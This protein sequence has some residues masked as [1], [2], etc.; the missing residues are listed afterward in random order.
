[1]PFM[2][3]G[4]VWLDGGKRQFTHDRRGR[5]ISESCDGRDRTFVY[6]SLDQLVEVRHPDGTNVRYEYDALRRR[7]A[8]EIGGKR[9]VFGW[10]GNR[11][12]WEVAADGTRR[13]YFY[14]KPEDYTPVM[15]CDV[16]VDGG[17]IKTYFIHHDHARRPILVTD[18][19]GDVVWSAE[20]AAYGRAV[21]GASSTLEFNLRAPGQYYDSETGLHYNYHRYYDPETGRYITPDPIG[22]AGGINT[23]TY[24]EGNPL[25]VCEVTA[26]VWFEYI[27]VLSRQNYLY[28]IERK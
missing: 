14:A 4:I 28:F 11:L 26:H 13:C 12:S 20:V 22:L 19:D 6:D 23:Y 17:D 16:P 21:V 1:M 7:T 24:G 8:K 10:D 2:I 5:V 27:N 25:V 18:K 15:F 3:Q 9:T